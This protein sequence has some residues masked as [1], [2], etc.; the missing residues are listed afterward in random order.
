MALHPPA[1]RPPLRLPPNPALNHPLPLPGPPSEMQRRQP[2]ARPPTPLSEIP[3]A[4]PAGDPRRV[5][6]LSLCARGVGAPP[7]VAYRRRDL[8]APPPPPPAA[9]TPCGSVG[10]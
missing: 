3:A 6:F 4:N 1:L 7:S 2:P 10:F 9:E 8:R 5:G